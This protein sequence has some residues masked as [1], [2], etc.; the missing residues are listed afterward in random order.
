MTK[1]N[2]Q[3]KLV[4]TVIKINKLLC[5][6][7]GLCAKNCP[8]GAISIHDKLAVIDRLKCNECG[9]CIDVCPRV[10]VTQVRPVSKDDLQSTVTSLKQKTNELIQRIESQRLK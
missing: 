2:Q 10:A 5:V 6:G 8:V 3:Q 4:N 1:T 7:C 9:I